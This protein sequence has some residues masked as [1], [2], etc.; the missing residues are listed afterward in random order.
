MRVGIAV[1]VISALIIPPAGWAQVAAGKKSSRGGAVEIE[2]I[3]V[4]AQKREERVQETPI[5]I[6]AITG[7]SLAQKG[8]A[9]VVDL[10]ESVPNLRLVSS[11][12]ETSAT[13]VTIRGVAQAVPDPS[14]QPTVGLYVDG[15]YLAKL[16]G[17]NI[18]LDD[19]ERVEVLRGPQG[20]LYGRNT[21]GG[22]VNFITKKPTDQRSATVSFEAGNYDTFNTRATFNVPLVGKNGFF[23]SDALGTISL[24]ETAGYLSHDGYFRNDGTASRIFQNQNRVYTRTALRWQ[25]TPAVTIDYSGEYHRYRDTPPAFQLTYIYPGA[26]TDAGR[27]FDVTPYVRTNRVDAITND[28]EMATD[29]SLH[30]IIDDGNHYLHTL[31]GSVD[32]GEVGPMG[33]IT[34]KSISSYRRFFTT[35]MA[36]YD[37]TPRNLYSNGRFSETQH[38]SQELQWL[39]TAP[40]IQYVLGAYYYGEYTSYTTDQVFFQ[41]GSIIGNKLFVKL[42]SYAPFGQVT[43]TPPIL[44]D[45]LSLTAGIRYTQE[46]FH[47]DR[48]RTGI[49]AP[50]TSFKASAGKA[51]GGIHGAGAP[52]ISPMANIAYQWTDNLMTYFRVSRG[53]KGGGF[54]GSASNALAFSKPFQPEK[55][56]AYEAGFKSEWF[57][58]RLR[59]NADGFYSDYTDLQESV[60]RPTLEAGSLSLIQN[61][62]NAEIW[63]TEFEGAVIPFRGV[64]ATASYSF[65]APKYTEWIDLVNGQL[66]D[67]SNQRAFPFAPRHQISAGLTYTAPPTSTGTFSA[68][69]D[70]YWQDEVDFIANNQT[71]GAQADKGWA[72]AVVNGRLQFVGIPLEKGTLD[73]AV[74]GENLFDRKYRTWGI[75]FSSSLGWAANGYG[76]PRTFGLQLTYNFTEAEAAPP[77]PAPVVQA[78]PPPP[79]AKKKIVLRSVH[80]DFDKATLKPEAKPILDE[81]IQ[82]LKQEG[83]VDI[84]VEGHTDSIGTEQYN[85][86]LSR[87][88]AATV[89]AYL[90]DHGIA[91]SRITAEGMGE[92]KPVA[93]N[94]TADGRA[95]NRRVELHVK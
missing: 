36:D 66:V 7:E 26:L 37:G 57:D 44:G 45:K 40:R 28:L 15:V 87:R 22:A 32:L 48:F 33:H 69:V 1:A 17:S 47:A 60:F 68:H 30:R 80:F 93:S 89:L 24:R 84:I 20:T 55:L 83:S 19:L 25:P 51:F 35:T 79:P 72:Y 42:K 14:L 53:F 18:D 85:L 58:K 91:R 70:T 90:V 29:R 92:A 81:A 74:F 94:D 8:V 82:V 71:P 56:L 39:G 3:I 73:L 31:T 63:G 76:V 46:Q 49:T 34:V 65:L 52:G 6:T 5:S 38:W 2:E 11:P 67:V 61:A 4:T 62:A 23:Q 77:P 95:Q 50:A 75:D 78:A 16:L 13:V 27:P 54:N 59:L 86:G 43:W 9:S 12:T 41:G 64:E 88:R 10:G 21:I